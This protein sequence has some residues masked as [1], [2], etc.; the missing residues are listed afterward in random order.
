MHIMDL[1]DMTIQTPQVSVIIP[2]YNRAR[3]LDEAIQSVLNQRFQDFELIVVDDGSS[4]DTPELVAQ[5]SDSRIRYVRHEE[6]RGISAALNTGIQA[7]R[8]EY[9]ARLDSDDIWLSKM[10]A[11]QI[12]ALNTHPKAGLAYAKTGAMD[13]DGTRIPGMWGQPEFFPGE[14]FKSL[15]YGDFTSN[16]TIVVRRECLDQ[17]GLYDE[18][19]QVNED[20]ELWLRVAR[21]YRFAFVDDVLAIRR[22]HEN[23]VTQINSPLFQEHL[24]G[25]SEVLDKV[26]SDSG[27]PPEVKLTR[28][29][30]ASDVVLNADAGQLGQ[31]VTN[32]GLNAVQALGDR[33]GAVHVG[34]S[35]RTLSAREAGQKGLEPGEYV[36]L[37][38]SDDGPGMDQEVADRVFEPF[39]TTK[40]RGRGTGLGLAIVAGVSQEMGGVA[41]VASRPGQG[42]V[43]TVWLPRRVAASPP[44]RVRL[45]GRALV[46][47]DQQD[48][49]ETLRRMLVELGLET[50]VHLDPAQALRAVE[51]APGAHRL[52]VTDLV[53]PGMDGL[54]LARRARALD[55]NLKV[56][57][58]TGFRHRLTPGQLAQAGVELVLDKPPGPG[59]TARA[60]IDLLQED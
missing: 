23:N 20:W 21:L 48:M 32:L 37:A 15:L 4:D 59:E 9:I 47:D 27:L 18:A 60:V 45:S 57:M 50:G 36:K 19:F 38:V 6:N 44:P 13:Q 17:V 58:C 22:W 16:V 7:S 5:I 51:A 12:Q 52:L 8:G 55:P 35:T 40:A 31:V 10:L 41:E 11:T 56:I 33:G 53:M 3:F 14:T 2:T 30:G 46:A 43:F 26:F 54:E 42:A 29:L 1:D 34:L 39:F 28:R 25:R 49:A 24:E